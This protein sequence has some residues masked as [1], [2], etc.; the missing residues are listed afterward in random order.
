MI[1]EKSGHIGYTPSNET[2]SPTTTSLFTS[3]VSIDNSGVALQVSDDVN[4]LPTDVLVAT[5]TAIEYSKDV[6]I[7]NTYKVHFA[8]NNY[9]ANDA[10]QN[11]NM[12]INSNKQYLAN[13]GNAISYYEWKIANTQK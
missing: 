10:G 3:K 7:G 9:F 4:S 6:N 13:T 1:Y 12:F 2:E 5:N 8:A 11:L